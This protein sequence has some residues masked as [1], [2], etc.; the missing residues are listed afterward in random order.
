MGKYNSIFG[1][2]IMISFIMFMILG[3]FFTSGD[4]TEEA[5]FLFGTVIILL[6]SF[7]ISLFFYLIDLVKKNRRI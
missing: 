1:L 6:L 3:T 5:V 2:V 7:L 4:P